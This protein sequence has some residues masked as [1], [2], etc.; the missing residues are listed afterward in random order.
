MIQCLGGPEITERVKQ[1]LSPYGTLQS[2]TPYPQGD[3]LSFGLYPGADL[4]A[5]DRDLDTDVLVAGSY[6]G[7]VTG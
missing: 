4:A 5:L 2:V 3:Q 1:I 7:K 6:R